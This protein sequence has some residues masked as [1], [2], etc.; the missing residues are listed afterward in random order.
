MV[1]AAAV[2]GVAVLVV[3]VGYRA[4]RRMGVEEL[5]GERVREEVAQKLG[6]REA[7]LG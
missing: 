5:K 7:G 4:G 3:L 2:S 6:Q 1:A